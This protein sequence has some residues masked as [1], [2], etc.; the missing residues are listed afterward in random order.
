M[1]GDLIIAVQAV[2]SVISAG[3]GLG[4]FEARMNG[5][6]CFPSVAVSG[7]RLSHF[8]VRILHALTCIPYFTLYLH[9]VMEL[10][11]GSVEF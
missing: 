10:R 1:H 9:M 6:E 4:P 2:C 7:L 11:E 8:I 3:S 5:H